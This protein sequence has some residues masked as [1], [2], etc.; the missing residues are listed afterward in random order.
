[1]ISGTV[2]WTEK[3]EIQYHFSA[4]HLKCFLRI[5]RLKN[6]AFLDVNN[7]LLVRLMVCAAAVGGLVAG[8]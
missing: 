8:L 1:M 4:A 7:P 2:S 3:S 6:E 5:F